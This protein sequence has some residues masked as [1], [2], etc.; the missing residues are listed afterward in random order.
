[1]Y[2]HIEQKVEQ[3]FAEALRRTPKSCICENPVTGEHFVPGH[4]PIRPHK[5]RAIRALVA[6]ARF[7]AEKSPDMPDMPL[8]EREYSATWKWQ[9]ALHYLVEAFTHSLR[10]QDFWL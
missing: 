6:Q 3:L 10:S 5:Q 4:G 1:M 7:A 8:N 9:S 2:P